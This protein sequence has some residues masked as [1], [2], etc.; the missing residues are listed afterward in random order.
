MIGPGRFRGTS[1]RR[2]TESRIKP[3]SAPRAEAAGLHAL[4][5][6]LADQSKFSLWGLR[7]SS[8]DTHECVASSWLC[9]LLLNSFTRGKAVQQ[10]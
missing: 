2:R 4:K 6:K 3:E 9:R 10:T 7:F 1:V 8:Y 5:L